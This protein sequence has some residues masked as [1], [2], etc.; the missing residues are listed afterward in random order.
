[1]Q[2]G[3]W[4][5]LTPR[6]S[7]NLSEMW[8]SLGTQ[9][10]ILSLLVNWWHVTELYSSIG[11][12]SCTFKKMSSDISHE[13][14]CYV[15]HTPK[16]WEEK[17]LTTRK[18]VSIWLVFVIKRLITDVCTVTSS[19]P[20]HTKAAFTDYVNHTLKQQKE[21][22]FYLFGSL[23]IEIC[24]GQFLQQS[25]TLPLHRFLAVFWMSLKAR[26]RPSLISSVTLSHSVHGVEVAFL[27]ADR[28]GSESYV[29]RPT[30]L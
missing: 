9:Y 4:Q 29:P 8:F 17:S 15:T 28:E 26:W 14:L 19:G 20:H 11:C 5:V 3:L 23:Q 25:L 13:Y 7:K 21:C 12:Y 1:M 10:M 6:M 16:N 30:P 2:P 18:H 24:Q 22:R 27:H